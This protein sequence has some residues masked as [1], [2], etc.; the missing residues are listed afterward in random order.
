MSKSFEMT[1][2]SSTALHGRRV[3]VADD[4][5]QTRWSYVGLLRDAG[6]R[7][8]EARDGVEA[9][10]LARANR[11]DLILADIAMPRLDGLGLCAAL[12][13]EPALGQVPVVLLS[14]GA[15]P[16]A[17]WGGGGGAARS[18]IDA[19]MATLRARLE[20]PAGVRAEPPAARLNEPVVVQQDPELAVD[21][22]EREDV[23]A[24]SMVAMHREPANH[25]SLEPEAVWRLRVSGAPEADGSA[26][27]FGAELSAMSRILGAGFV[28]LL[29]ATIALLVWRIA[30]TPDSESTPT[31]AATTVSSER[32]VPTLAARDDPEPAGRRGIAAFAGELVSDMD[33]SVGALAGQGALHLDGPQTVAVSVDGEDA[34]S[35]PVA[36]PLDEGVHR[37]RYRFE[38][39]VSDRFYFVKSGATRRLVVIT[40]PDGFVDDR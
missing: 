36:L 15:P 13:E 17:V 22:V 11:P 35:L 21:E 34:G 12:R 32:E 27:G 5:A 10:A 30:N 7:V 23:R 8:T 26:S 38:D 6:A 20:A 18:L 14:D 16:Q 40:R 28:T 25:V 39:Q 4:V 3:L 19:V 31:Q 9:L 37:V 29:A 33:P 2:L 1:T 24:Q